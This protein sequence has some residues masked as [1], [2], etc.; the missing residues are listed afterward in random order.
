MTL[1][2]SLVGRTF[3]PTAE[4]HVTP[5]S[6]A[7][8]AAA[9]GG[10]PAEVAPPTYPIVLAFEAMQTFLDAE[11]VPL[12]R[13]VHGEQRFTYAR[14][15]VAGDTLVATLEVARLRQIGGND[16]IGTL[17]TVTDAA[18]ELVCTATATLV[19]RGEAT[20]EDA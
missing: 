20:E 2:S 16:I 12:H 15:I 9:A 10:A 14:P 13:I 17:S 18:G 11:Q 1:D 5:E 19:H 4:H 6:I 7:A 3:P 8:F